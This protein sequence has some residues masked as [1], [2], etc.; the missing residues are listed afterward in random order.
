MLLLKRSK[1]RPGRGFGVE[2]GGLPSWGLAD[3]VVAAPSSAVAVLQH[4]NGGEGE[5]LGRFGLV[6]SG[7]VDWFSSL[8]SD[9]IVWFGLVWFGVH[10]GKVGKGVNVEG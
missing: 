6:G 3:P 7:L 5:G 4:G 1:Q 10:Q 8:G 2:G 9:I